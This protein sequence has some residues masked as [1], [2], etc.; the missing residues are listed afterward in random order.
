MKNPLES[1]SEST[2][3]PL[4][5]LSAT[6]LSGRDK[7][8]A[9]EAFGRENASVTA[10]ALRLKLLRCPCAAACCVEPRL[11]PRACLAVGFC[12]PAASLA[13][14]DCCNQQPERDEGGRWGFFR[15]FWGGSL[16]YLSSH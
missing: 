10:A 12:R 11:R 16:C 13:R 7:I 5:L 1:L 9:Q 3:L 6:S 8:P 15:G 2:L 14:P 4:L